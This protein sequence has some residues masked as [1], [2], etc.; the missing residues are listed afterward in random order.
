MANNVDAV[1][2]ARFNQLANQWWDAEGDFKTLHKINPVR[3]DYVIRQTGGL[4]NKTVLDVGCGGGILAESMAVLGAAV[5]A[6]D[7]A[8]DSIAAAKAHARAQ[9][10]EINYRL[11]AAD[12]LVAESDN[13]FDVVTCMELLEHVPHPAELITVCSTLCKTEGHIVFSTINRTLQAFSLAIV[14]AEYLLKLLP[15]GTHDYDKFIRPSELAGWSRAA[16]LEVRDISGMRYN[17]L[18]HRASLTK[19]VSVNYL[20]F[21]RKQ[22][23]D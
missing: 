9:S 8:E 3:M 13:R 20:M 1:E 19:D 16:G 21:C 7:L 5:T 23:H 2:V 11:A 12:D 17:P 14:G 22:S 15:A 10:L 4:K 6:I 18:N